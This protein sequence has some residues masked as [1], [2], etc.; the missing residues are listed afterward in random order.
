MPRPTHN[1]ASYLPGLD[2]L[3]AVA[4]TLVLLYHLSVPG[5]AGGLMGVGVFFTL[6]GYLITSLLIS[7]RE[8]HG[9]LGLTTFWIRRARR[10]LPAV[11]LVLLTTLA[12]AA[13]A[14]PDKLVDYSWQ[15]ASALFYVNNWHTI[16]GSDSYFQRFDGPG[17]LSHMWSL[18][19]EEQFYI[20]WPLLLAL[21]Y[22]V[23]KRR[24]VISGFIALLSLGSFWLLSEV[25]TAGFDNT[26]AYEGTD[27]RAG[28]LLLGALLAFWWPARGHRV[29]EN[30]RACIDGVGVAGLVGIVWLSMTMP[31][32]SHDLYTWGLLALTAATLAVLIGAV[33]PSSL[34]AKI[35][36]VQPLRWIGERSYGIYLWHM[37]LVAF[38]PGLIRTDSAVV[39]SVVVVAATVLLSSLSWRYVE[40]PIRRHG[41]RAAFTTPRLAEDTVLAHLVATLIA[42]VDAVGRALRGLLGRL[43]DDGPRPAG[44]VQ[45]GSV[46]TGSAQI[47]TVWDAP[48]PAALE[49]APLREEPV[50]LTWPPI[51][52][53][54][55]DLRARDTA[56]SDSAT[57]DSATTDS[58][59]VDSAA[60]DTVP[61]APVE[62]PTPLRRSPLRPVLAMIAVLAVAVGTMVGVAR[63]SPDLSV[64]RALSN[65]DDLE[66]SGIDD[67]D[68]G[69]RPAAVGPTLPENLRRTRCTTLV[70]VG[71]STSIGMNAAE[72]QP[73]P[74]LRLSGRYAAVGVTRY[75]SDVVGGRSSLEEVDGEPNAHDSIVR[76][77]ADGVRGCWVM[78][79]GI[80]D[81]ANVE[82]GGPGPLDMRIDRLLE[83]LRGQPV[84]WPTIVTNR[85]NENP[86]Y[87]NRAMQRFN[88]ALV[89]ACKRYPNLR[90]YDWAAEVQQ[91][92]FKDGVHY[93][94][95]GY[96]ERARRFAV[97]VA[98]MFPADD[99]PPAGCVLRSTDAVEKTST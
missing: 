9:T 3:R 47:A 46:Q 34:I 25:A 21:L 76:D 84:L 68:S 19:I 73:N 45:T 86:A 39:S 94:D 18:S 96:V 28:A 26:R 37:P 78:A 57:T 23:F 52:E 70:H 67:M 53:E 8:K 87:D 2:G 32:T 59:A 69:P 65:S 10:L 82:V 1:A 99:L 14:A 75:V 89:R 27:T 97:A 58:A 38:L 72:L 16:A 83:P 12:T 7:S 29:S 41:F 56:E 5:F 15:A 61:P 91:N 92:W 36:G 43:T 71:D 35:L 13:V 20:V 85:L 22:A 90:V 6:S 60:V 44:S 30:A 24:M 62:E 55:V 50:D 51:A 74:A 98:T 80:N 33:T 49:P 79:M 11:V 4:V 77:V 48:A 31:G 88:R 66:G 95:A 63:I 54:D 64:I 40:D 17:P 81:T 42:G 93:T